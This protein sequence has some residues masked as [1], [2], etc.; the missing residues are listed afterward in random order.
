MHLNLD[1][2]K[3]DKLFC[4]ISHAIRHQVV[5]AKGFLKPFTPLLDDF[6]TTKPTLGVISK[7]EQELDIFKRLCLDPLGDW[8]NFV[9]SRLEDETELDLVLDMIYES[10]KKLT[11]EF[12]RVT[13]RFLYWKSVT[14]AEPSA[15]ESIGPLL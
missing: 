10:Q 1:E 14:R 4:H 3:C 11:M 6:S 9:K 5:K 2:C 12:N 15:V 13:E 8:P 7:L